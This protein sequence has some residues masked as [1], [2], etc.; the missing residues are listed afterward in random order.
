MQDSTI[1]TLISAYFQKI[2]D[3]GVASQRVSFGTSGHRGTSTNGSFNQAHIWAISQAIV[4]YRTAAGIFGPLYLGIDTH[5]LSE[6]AYGSVIEV[7]VAQGVDVYVHPEGGFT[8]TPLIS[9]AILQH[10]RHQPE[11]LADGIVITPSHNPP[12]DGG[13]KYNTPDGGPAASHVTREVQDRA[14]AL[15]ESG[16]KSIK[17]VSLDQARAGVK[18]FDFV[19]LYVSHLPEAINIEAIER[20]GLRIGVDPMG[21]TSLEVWQAIARRFRIHLSIVNTVQDP[22]FSF[23]PPDHDGQIRM[24]CSSPHAM[25]NLLRLRNRYD[26]AVANDPDADR[27]GIVDAAGLMN[28]N[29]FLAVAVDYLLT[30]RPEWGPELA[31]GKTL[32]SSSILDRV[33]AKHGRTLYE[34]PVGFKWFVEGLH[35]KRLAF[36]GEESAG[37]SF[38]TLSGEPWSTDKDGILLCLLAA[39]LYAVTGK[40]PSQYYQELTQSLGLPHYKRIDAPATPAEK[41]VLGWLQASHIRSSHL[42]GEPITDIQVKAPGNVESIGGVKVITQSGWFAARPSGTESIYKIYAESFVDE[43]HLD[44]LVSEARVIVDEMLS[45]LA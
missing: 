14:N 16:F 12:G 10:N 43:A 20:F 15:L 33:V 13:I 2:P 6:P 39:E 34:V 8:P 23:M 38:L 22:A 29:H 44:Q 28:P 35:Q 7:L 3:P 45:T 18:P 40:S 27:H 24:D 30:H 32:V 11:V 9:H 37:A 26:L 31:I 41:K 4:E 1:T 19:D 21:G 5:A 25:A 36:A 17:R 42:V